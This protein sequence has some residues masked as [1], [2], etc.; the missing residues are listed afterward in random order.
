M[1]GIA[2]YTGKKEAFPFLVEALDRMHYRGY[3]SYGITTLND[4]GNSSNVKDITKVNV[5]LLKN[6]TNIVGKIGLGHTRW[7]THGEVSIKNTHPICGTKPFSNNRWFIVHNGIIDNHLKIKELLLKDKYVYETNTDTESAAHLIHSEG[8]FE[9]VKLLTGQYAIVGMNSADVNTLYFAVNGSPLYVSTDGYIASDIQALSEYT[10]YAYRIKS[11]TAG[12]LNKEGLQLF[13]GTLTNEDYCKVPNSTK[14]TI[15]S[16]NMLDEIKEQPK[17]ILDSQ[18][19]KSKYWFT[20]NGITLFGCGSSYYASMLGQKYFD[21]NGIS[22]QTVYSTDLVEANSLKCGDIYIGLSQSGETKD[23][24]LALEKVRA[25]SPRDTFIITNNPYSS[26]AKFAE[27]IL[28]DCGV[29]RGVAAT[30][31]FLTQVLSLYKLAFPHQE[32][33]AFSNLSLAIEEVLKNKE[34]ENHAKELIKYD[35]M[36]Y[37]GRG[38][39]YPI[40]LEGALKMKEVAYKHAEAVMA[41]EIKHGPIALIDNKTISVVIFTSQDQDHISKV[42]ANLQE[43]KARKGKILAIVDE[44]TYNICRDLCDFTITI[45]YLE[46]KFLQPLIS[47]TV[48]QLLAYYAAVL[49]NINPDYPRNLAKAVTV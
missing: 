29:E 20:K 8:F 46:N 12:K 15:S 6:L 32:T 9:A 31:T 39:N 36:L 7:A 43:I 37:L 4:N 22:A 13:E 17:L 35:H 19:K 42:F 26:G 27:P 11:G 38:M 34:I 18:N 1:C 16:H 23:T 21:G 24:L 28:L 44:R 47:V 48:L 2:A 40:A 5:E 45:P 3:D 41:S 30:K 33:W 25:K 14:Q 10:E 49:Q